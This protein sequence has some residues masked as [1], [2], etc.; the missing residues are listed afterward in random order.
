MAGY[1]ADVCNSIFLEGVVCQAFSY[2][3]ATKL[4]FFKGQ[5]PTSNIIDFARAACVYPNV[6]LWSLV[7]GET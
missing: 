3:T 5:L 7:S 2:N 4:A 1:L 6:T